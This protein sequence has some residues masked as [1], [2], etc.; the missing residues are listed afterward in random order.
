MDV[1]TA[2]IRVEAQLQEIIGTERVAD[3]MVRSRGG[4]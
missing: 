3:G 2:M 1:Q 4:R